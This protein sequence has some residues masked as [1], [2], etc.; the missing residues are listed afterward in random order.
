MSDTGKKAGLK[1]RGEISVDC[2]DCGAALMRFLIVRN[3]VDLAELGVD[4]VTTTVRCKCGICGGTSYVKTIEGQF[5]PGAAEDNIAFEVQDPPDGET[6]VF[7]AW[8]H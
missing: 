5:Y 8:R 2:A 1:N 4:P 7:R 3:N 6:I